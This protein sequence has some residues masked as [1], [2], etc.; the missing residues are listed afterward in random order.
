MSRKTTKMHIKSH[1]PTVMKVGIFPLPTNK[2]LKLVE[3]ICGAHSG[4]LPP[5][6]FEIQLVGCGEF[7]CDFSRR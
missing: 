6:P 4:P 1:Q 5:P 2:L 3:L 7:L